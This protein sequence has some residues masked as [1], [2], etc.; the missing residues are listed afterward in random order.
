MALENGLRKKEWL[1]D[2]KLFIRLVK[3]IVLIK[4]KLEQD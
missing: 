1:E 2:Q 4:I 3:Y